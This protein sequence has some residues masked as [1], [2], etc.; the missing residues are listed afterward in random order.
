MYLYH[1][2]PVIK[3]IMLCFYLCNSV[4]GCLSYSLFPMVHLDSVLTDVADNGSVLPSDGAGCPTGV[5]A[6]GGGELYSEGVGTS[7]SQLPASDEPQHTGQTSQTGQIGDANGG[8]S[9]DALL[10]AHFAK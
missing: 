7:N 3:I 8:G 2:Y 10:A 6:G 4:C 5:A 1:I 9:E